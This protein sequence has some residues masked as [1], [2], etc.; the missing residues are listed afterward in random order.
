[1]LS[2][3]NF[4]FLSWKNSCINHFKNNIGLTS[5]ISHGIAKTYKYCISNNVV[6]FTAKCEQL[7]YKVVVL[8]LKKQILKKKEF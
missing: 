4:E 1:M 2:V 5:L 6:S 8:L 3:G 7:M